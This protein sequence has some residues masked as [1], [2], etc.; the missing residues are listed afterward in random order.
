MYSD[1]QFSILPPLP[2]KPAET[3]AVLYSAP[4]PF[5]LLSI[6]SLR[7]RDDLPQ[8]FDWVNQSYAR[9][10]WQIDGSPEEMEQ[11]CTNVLAS[12]H[13][14]S[15][16]VLL[17]GQPVAQVDLYQVMADELGTQITAGLPDCGIHLLT[18]PPRKFRPGQSRLILR[19]FMAFYFS[20][21]G[22]DY[23]YA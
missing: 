11:C 18:L 6:R 14:H 19:S 4:L 13:A 20:G 15:L 12:P 1:D 10:F 7:L 21:S 22:A 17:D 3:A 16:M 9:R 5:G 2:L 23:L 8:L